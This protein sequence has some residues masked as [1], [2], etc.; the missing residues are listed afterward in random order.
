MLFV[1]VWFVGKSEAKELWFEVG[2][3]RIYMMT[4]GH[5]QGGLDRAGGQTWVEARSV[6]CPGISDTD[7]TDPTSEWT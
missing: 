2:W 5:W 7:K 3:F 4:S 6:L 1:C